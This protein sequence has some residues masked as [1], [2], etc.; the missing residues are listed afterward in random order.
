MASVTAGTWAAARAMF[1]SEHDFLVVLIVLAATVPVALCFGVVLARRV[2]VLSR[3]STQL[4]ADRR[5]EA[6]VEAARREMVASVSHDLRTPLAGI[7]AMAESLED[8][9]APDPPR[10]YTR[11]R[12]EADRLGSMVDDLLALA[13]LQSG[14][15]HL[16]RERVDLS[17]LVSDT[18]SQAHP[19]A[20]ERGVHLTGVTDSHAPACVDPREMS[21]ALTN[22][23][24]NAVRHTPAGGTVAVEASAEG[25]TALLRVLDGCGGLTDEEIERVFDPGWRGASA[26]GLTAGAGTGLGLAIV[27]GVVHAHGGQVSVVNVGPGCRFEVRLPAGDRTPPSPAT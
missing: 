15:L 18:L 5:R 13:R 17:D 19:L 20:A 2:H 14:A 11:I 27:R 23:V 24:V 8:R 9:V 6:E 12:A 1:L 7:R 4:S 10:Y 3:R 21:R 22:L 16:L 25:D 26:R